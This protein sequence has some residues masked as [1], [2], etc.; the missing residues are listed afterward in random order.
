MPCI[1]HGFV[2]SFVSSSEPVVEKE[3][4]TQPTDEEQHHVDVITDGVQSTHVYVSMPTHANSDSSEAAQLERRAS[5]AAAMALTNGGGDSSVFMS[6]PP[7]RPAGSAS[8]KPKETR[9]PKPVSPPPVPPVPAVS[10]AMHSHHPS[11]AS[12]KKNGK[13]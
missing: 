6:V 12:P 10:A 11:R 4:A 13:P 5:Q 3:N 2:A 8:S 7:P 9:V 1:A